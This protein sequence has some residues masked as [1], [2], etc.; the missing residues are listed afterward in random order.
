MLFNPIFKTYTYGCCLLLSLVCIVCAWYAYQVNARRPKDD[1]QKRNFHLG[2]VI[3]APILW[4]LFPLLFISL[5]FLRAIVFSILLTSSIIALLVVRKPFLFIWLDKIMT[6]IGNKLLDANTLL[7]RL[8][9]GWT[10]E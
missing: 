2:A 1:P 7:I 5:F 8:F 4:P 3:L 9:F 10:P 6:K